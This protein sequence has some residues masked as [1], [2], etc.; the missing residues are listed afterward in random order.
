V[1]DVW[2]PDLALLAGLYDVNGVDNPLVIADMARYWEGTDGRSTRLYDLLGVRYVLGSK[3]VTLDWDKFTLAFDGDPAVNVYRNE[4]ALP[5][6]FVVHRAVVAG[7]HA[8]AWERIHESGFDP[9]TLVVLEGGQPLDVPTEGQATV[10]V[11]RYEPDS[12]AIAVDSPAEGYLVLSD[13]FYPG[14]RALVD[15]KAA[16]ILRADY[17]FRA[18]AVPAGTHQVTMTFQPRSWRV[19]LGVSVLTALILLALT[20]VTLGRRRQ[21]SR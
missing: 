4:T 9:A 7:D 18:V 3:Q 6:A 20:G 5:R 10:Q 21:A 11:V 8:E 17:A 19:G 1:G 16:A 15:G 2:Q 12:L 14:W 13:P